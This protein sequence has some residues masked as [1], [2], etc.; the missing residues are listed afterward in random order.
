MKIVASA[1]ACSLLMLQVG[2]QAQPAQTKPDAARKTPAR[3]SAPAWNNRNYKVNFDE[4][5][6]QQLKT[7]PDLPDMPPWPTG[8]KLADAIVTPNSK[9]GP[10]YQVTFES[11]D[12]PDKVLLF[13]STVLPTYKWRIL[14][15]TKIGI[16]ATRGDANVSVSTLQ[17]PNKKFPCQVLYLYS[18][19]TKSGISQ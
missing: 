8:Y 12:P 18:K 6:W 1:L 16:S 9:G 2:A 4:Y 10:A 15:K 19:D 7:A 11:T 3:P 14:N 17:S 13:Y 5:K